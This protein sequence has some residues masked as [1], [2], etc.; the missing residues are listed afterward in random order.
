MKTIYRVLVLGLLTMALTAVTAT[1]LF[2]QDPCTEVEAKQAVYKKFTDNYA[3]K[4]IG[5][6]KIAVEAGKEYIQKYG[7]CPDDK[8][9]VTY[10]NSTVPGIEKGIT[11]AEGSIKK[12]E[13]YTRFDT[14][15]KAKNTADIFSVG[16]EILAQDPDMLDVTL[17]L[18]TAGYDQAAAKPPVD[19][20]NNEAI[21]Y[22]R[23]AIQKI[24]SGTKSTTGDFGVLTYSYKTKDNALGW[25]NY[26]IGYVDYYRLG[27]KDE[28][29]TYLY[30]ASMAPGGATTKTNAYLYQT[31]GAH[32][33]DEVVRLGKKSLPKLKQPERK[34]TKRKRYS[35]WKKVM[36]IARLTLMPEPIKRLIRKTKHIK[37][38][39]MKR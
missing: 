16:K 34:P 31:I 19:T 20:Y 11:A 7:N 8:E 22:A 26:I 4:E 3:S 13:L 35:R 23:S 15:L 25:M 1:S 28:G 6:R 30:K 18:A 12:N 17:V 21:N 9:I 37:T 32:Y 10:L 33:R 5:K 29:L 39:F 14:A 2:A 36:Q 24:E 38:G 27:K